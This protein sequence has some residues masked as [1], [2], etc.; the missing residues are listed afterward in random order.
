MSNNTYL[1][2]CTQVYDLSKPTPPEEAY[3]FY[4]SYIEATRGPILEP[5]CGSG[6]FLFGGSQDT[7]V[8]RTFHI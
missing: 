4:R 1:K 6:R 7:C 8:N 5:M 2:L 3:A